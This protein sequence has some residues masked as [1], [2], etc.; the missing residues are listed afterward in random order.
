MGLVSVVCELF[1]CAFG[2]SC[3]RLHCP[4]T[5]DSAEACDRFVCDYCTYRDDCER[6]DEVEEEEEE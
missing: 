4:A 1:V 5:D 3:D 2:D 6:V